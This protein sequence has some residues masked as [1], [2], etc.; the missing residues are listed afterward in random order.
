M[1]RKGGSLT[2]YVVRRDAEIAEAENHGLSLPD[3]VKARYLE[4]GAALSQ[5]NRLNMRTLAGGRSDLASVRTAILMLNVKE[6][7]SVLR[8]SHAL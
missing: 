1:I 2:E 7:Q 6:S 4:E 3:E 8:T 5:Q